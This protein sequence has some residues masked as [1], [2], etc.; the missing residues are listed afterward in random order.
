MSESESYGRI[1][2]SLSTFY[3]SQVTTHVGYLISSIALY[4]TAIALILSLSGGVNAAW[5]ATL[6]RIV[7]VTQHFV[8]AEI[9]LFA[10]LSVLLF[11]VTGFA[12]RPILK[13]FLGRTQYYICLSEIVL[14]H[15]RAI[16]PK[17]GPYFQALRKKAKKYGAQNAIQSLF[18]FQLYVSARRERDKTKYL[19]MPEKLYSPDCREAFLF[20]DF[21]DEVWYGEM[22]I[23]TCYAESKVHL[24]PMLPFLSWKKTDLLLR[25]YRATIEGYLRDK[26]DRVGEPSHNEKI[27]KL[28]EEFL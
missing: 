14:D 21:E 12:F 26:S 6:V 1:L 18:E 5:L 13:Y 25:A 11:V 16:D 23:A 20:N 9:V 15:M 2:D 4:V 27:G 24:L 3:N 22:V 7:G 10:V 28:F 19:R 17:S 8:A